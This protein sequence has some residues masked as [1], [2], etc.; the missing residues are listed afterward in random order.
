MQPLVALTGTVT[1][2]E[3]GEENVVGSLDLALA[4]ARAI[5]H[6]VSPDGT[7][8]LVSKQHRTWH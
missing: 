7:L 4:R 8:H 6:D 3:I 2:R 5:M 1:M